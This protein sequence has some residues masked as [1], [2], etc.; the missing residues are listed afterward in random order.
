[1]KQKLTIRLGENQG[2]FSM[3][4]DEVVAKNIFAKFVQE[5]AS[6]AV[7]I[8]EEVKPNYEQEAKACSKKEVEKP[9]NTEIIEKPISVD[10]EEAPKSNFEKVVQQIKEAK[11]EEVRTFMRPI[12]QSNNTKREYSRPQQITRSNRELKPRLVFYTCVECGKTSYAQALPQNGEIVKCI[13]KANNVIS[14]IKKAEAYCV[15]CG[16]R[17]LF[18][19]DKNSNFKEIRC[20]NCEAFIDMRYV[21]KKDMYVSMSL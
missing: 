5:V 1:M 17:L 15:C 11:E 3:E 4:V 9:K 6:K 2:M 8:K 14:D 7:E 20:K 13:C 12:G 21:E 18:F 10:I 16:T 19:V